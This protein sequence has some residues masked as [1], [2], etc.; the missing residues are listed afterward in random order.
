MLIPGT[1]VD[2]SF[3]T[4][5]K[6][7][8]P[9]YYGANEGSLIL[10]SVNAGNSDGLCVGLRGVNGGFPT[11]LTT[12]AKQQNVNLNG[13]GTTVTKDDYHFRHLKLLAKAGKNGAAVETYSATDP[14]AFCYV[15]SRRVGSNVTN[16]YEG[17][18][19]VDVFDA[20][21]RPWANRNNACM[22]YV[23]P[24]YGGHYSS[25]AAF[26]AAIQA[27]AVNIIKTLAGYNAIAAQSLTIAAASGAPSI[28]MNPSNATVVEGGTV[29]FTAAA[30]P[31]T[32]PAHWE[33]SSDNGSTFTAVPNQTTTTL[34]LTGVTAASMKNDQ[35]RAVFGTGSLTSATTAATLTVSRVV[36]L[37]TDTATEG[38]WIGGYGNDKGGAVL[39]PRRRPPIRARYRIPPAWRLFVTPLLTS[40][41]RQANPF[42]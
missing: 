3:F 21:L 35:Y 19:F 22:L 34:T 7:L 31:S 9:L 25:D 14:S 2:A 33:V 15:N 8:P 36:F 42:R 37:G 41:P 23:A 27:T 40:R 5:A 29:T 4:F 18:C 17:V 32:A 11:E 16:W 10:A 20:G 26:L 38:N 6:S 13:C 24:P 12:N 30:A 1:N 28:T 39:T